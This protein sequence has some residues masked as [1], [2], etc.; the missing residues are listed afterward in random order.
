M[1]GLRKQWILPTLKTSLNC[2][3][4]AYAV[5]Q[6]YMDIL[7]SRKGIL[8]IDF[9]EAHAAPSDRKEDFH[10]ESPLKSLT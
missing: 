6:Q 3:F 8:K 2:L 1:S 9:R 7:I 4:W 10:S 5:P